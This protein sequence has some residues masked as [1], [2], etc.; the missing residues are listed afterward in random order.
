[1]SH[2]LVQRTH[3]SSFL[4]INLVFTRYILSNNFS[5]RSVKKF[6]CKTGLVKWYAPR[7][8]LILSMYAYY[9]HSFFLL[10]ANTLQRE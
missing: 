1:M 7:V 2:V 10:I 8:R 9:F 4:G 6:Q 3:F 5:I